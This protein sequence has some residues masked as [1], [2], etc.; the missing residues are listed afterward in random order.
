MTSSLVRVFFGMGWGCLCEMV[1]KVKREGAVVES[2][3]IS[4]SQEKTYEY[5]GL[6][7]DEIKSYSDANLVTVSLVKNSGT[8]TVFQITDKTTVNEMVQTR[9]LISITVVKKGSAISPGSST[10]HEL[11]TNHVINSAGEVAL[12][13]IL[14]ESDLKTYAKAGNEVIAQMTTQRTIQG[15]QN[16]NISFTKRLQFNLN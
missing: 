7:T 3:S 2:G 15:D 9:Y 6:T 14:K 11:L 10:T 12:S 5:K 1:L 13:Q 16:Q 4:F 8:K